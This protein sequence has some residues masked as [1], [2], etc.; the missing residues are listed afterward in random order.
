MPRMPPIVGW[1]ASPWM[2]P[3]ISLWAIAFRMRRS[4]KPSIRYAVHQYGDPPGTM[5]A[6]AVIING[7]GVNTGP[8]G[9]WGDYSAMNVDPVDQCTFWYT[10]EYHDVDSRFVQL[11]YPG[12]CV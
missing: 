6:E 12:G 2:A 8:Y 5:Q 11:E 1:A 7:N 9:R 3:A 10:N 4:T